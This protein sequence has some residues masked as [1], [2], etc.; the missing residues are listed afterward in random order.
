MLC[1]N[2]A[3]LCHAVLWVQAAVPEVPVRPGSHKDAVLGLSWNR[4]FRNVLASASADTTVKVWDVAT[5]QCNSTL[6]HHTGK[7]QAV[8]WNPAEAPVLLSGGFDARACLVDM[9]VEGGSSAAAWQVRLRWCRCSSWCCRS[10][11]AAAPLPLHVAGGCA[12]LL[13]S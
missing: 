9:R 5:Q 11:A 12:C 8:A 13:L 3:V 1:R 4:E 7:V 2:R 6:R 10:M